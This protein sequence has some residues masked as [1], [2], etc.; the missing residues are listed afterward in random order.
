MPDSPGKRDVKEKAVQD[1]DEVAQEDDTLIGCAEELHPD[2]GQI[3]HARC[4]PCHHV[5]CG[6]CAVQDFL[7]YR[8]EGPGV[9]VDIHHR[10]RQEEIDGRQQC[11]R[12][13]QVKRQA[14]KRS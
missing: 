14:V 9:V 13:K 5:L 10:K 4:L 8:D 6:N 12:D 7:R 11:R 3:V 2:R 1:A